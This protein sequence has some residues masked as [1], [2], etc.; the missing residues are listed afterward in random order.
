MCADY[1]EIS[2]LS[3]EAISSQHSYIVE[4]FGG[5][6]VKVDYFWGY[7]FVQTV[8]GTG[9]SKSRKELH[10]AIEGFLKRSECGPISWF[11]SRSPQRIA[12][13]HFPDHPRKRPSCIQILKRGTTYFCAL[14]FRGKATKSI[15]EITKGSWNSLKLSGLHRK[16]NVPGQITIQR[17]LV[18]SPQRGTR[19]AFR[20]RIKHPCKVLND[21]TLEVKD[22]GIIVWPQIISMFAECA[23]VWCRNVLAL[24]IRT[25]L[26]R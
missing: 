21:I 1:N 7:L 16:Y 20:A 3:N 24:C 26:W 12:L 13:S 5:H 2:E 14:S 25:G 18:P 15:K 10:K 9:S 19:L 22:S 4:P 11:Y 23:R 17:I 8:K 6:L